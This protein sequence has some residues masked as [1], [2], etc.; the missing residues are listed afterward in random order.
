MTPVDRPTA[1]EHKDF[2]RLLARNVQLPLL[3]GLAGAVVFVGLIF[4]LLSVI[5]W[6]E[7]TDRVTRDAVEAQREQAEMQSAVRGFLLTGNADFLR[8]FEASERHAQELLAELQTLV[9]DNP[10][11]AARAADLADLQRRWSDYARDVI[12]R[13][14]GG[15]PNETIL[16]A[17]RGKQ[18]ADEIRSISNTFVQAE[19]A[20]RD[21]RN[22]QANRTAVS[23]VIGYLLF[24]VLVSGVLAFFGRRQLMNLSEAYG[25]TI[26]EQNTQAQLLQ[27]QAWLR[28]AQTELA[29]RTVGQLSAQD[30][31]TQV[32]RFFA[33][34]AGSVVGAAY[35]REAQGSLRRVATYGFSREAE[36]DRK[37]VV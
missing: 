30:L 14:R 5:S 16:Q 33:E 7:H 36:A 17:G 35:V 6:V 22:R 28:G 8:P 23:T 37:S 11:Q 1:I 13:K 20:L 12:E 32:L 3:L 25:K 10:P 19:H 21:A 24:S 34:Q 29:S 27:E 4:Y 31:G 9:A 15:E 26:A 2:R 18:L